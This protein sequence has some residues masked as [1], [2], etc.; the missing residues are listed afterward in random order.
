MARETRWASGRGW[1]RCLRYSSFGGITRL[2]VHIP[3]LP[4][5]TSLIVGYR[6]IFGWLVVAV[7]ISTGAGVLY[8]LEKGSDWATGF[9]LSS[10]AI[11]CFGFA[12]AIVALGDHVGLATPGSGLSKGEDWVFDIPTQR[13]ITGSRLE[14]LKE[15]LEDRK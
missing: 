5:T 12:I 14:Q 3:P 15:K 11:T 2:H 7:L 9:S 13:L 1:S 10:Y 6:K 8:A 4:L